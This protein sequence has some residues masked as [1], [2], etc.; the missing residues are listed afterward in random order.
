MVA[1]QHGRAISRNMLLTAHFEAVDKVGDDPGHKAQQIL[2][3]QKEHIES[4]DG[5]GNARQQENLRN[6]GTRGQQRASQNAGDDHEQGVQDVVGRNDAGTVRGL[7][8]QLNQR[9]HG[10]AVNTGR[11]R[12]HSQI[13]HHP[14]VSGLGDEGGDTHQLRRRQAAHRKIQVNGKHAHA[15]CAQRHQAN[16]YMAAAEHLAQ[17]RTDADTDRK[18]HQQQRSHMLI[19]MQHLFG[20]AGEL[21]QKHGAKEPH[22]ADAQQRAKHRRLLARHLQV[23]PGLGKGVPVDDQ[24][25]IGSWSMRNELCTDPAHNRQRH[26]GN[27]DFC[28]ADLGHGHQQTTGDL[29]QQDGNKSAHL[30]H[31]IAAGQFALIEHLGQIGKLHRAKQRGMQA[32]QKHAAQ[33]HRHIGGHKA[34]GRQQHD[35]DLQV[36]D[37]AE[38]AGLVPLVR[39]LARGGREQQIRQG[40]QGANHQPGHRGRQPRDAELVR[41]HHREGE[42][43]QIVIGR[44]GKLGPEE[45]SKAP[46]TQQGKLV[47]VGLG[48]VGHRL[49]MLLHCALLGC[50][51][52]TVVSELESCAACPACV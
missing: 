22:P 32:H 30:H 8:A 36:L 37:Q 38:H 6:A 15:N 27:S 18:H 40:K 52:T 17:Q 34:P 41:H 21:G 51:A 3:H 31:A 39:Q 12:H 13:K 5:V 33:Q 1:D 7:A 9:I 49:Y 24:I 20:K 48:L 43:E 4:H 50:A 23:A 14:P 2:W 11:Q 42:L 25:R 46:L 28:V 19:A 45:R 26:T 44:A 47:G 29:A 16:F 10:H 35:A